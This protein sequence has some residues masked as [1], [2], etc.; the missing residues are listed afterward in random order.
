MNPVAYILRA[1][2][3]GYQLVIS[4]VL[5]AS[6]RYYPTCSSYTLQAIETH[7]ALKGAW[8]GLKRIGRC[9]PWNDGGYDPVP[10]TPEHQD[11]HKQTHHTH[12]HSSCGC[13]PDANV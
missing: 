12:T 4:P 5:P 1:L 7:G 9:H 3:K 13:A 2:V 8:M 10:G 11:H 6:C